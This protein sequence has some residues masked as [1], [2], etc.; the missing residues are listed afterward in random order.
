MLLRAK[1]FSRFLIRYQALTPTTNIPPNT[2]PDETAW[3]NLLTAT[4][5]STSAQKSSI[6]FRAVSGSNFIPTGYCIHELATNIQR[7]DMVAPIAVSHVEA[8]WNLLLTLFQPKNMTAMKVASIKKAIIPSMARGAS[9]NI[10]YEPAIIRPVRTELKFED[11][12]RCYSDCKIDSEKGHQYLVI[13]F[14]R[15]SPVR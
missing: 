3:K 15:S 2:Q 4:G 6:T 8:K 7:A 9:E 10:A 13:V 5:E 11:N 12:T 14:H 1:K